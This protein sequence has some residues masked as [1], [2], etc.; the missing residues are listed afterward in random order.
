MTPRMLLA[1]AV[2]Y[3]PAILIGY[4]LYLYGPDNSC[5]LGSLCSFGAFPGI[6]QLF[7]LIVGA[8]LLTAVVFVPLWWLLDEARPARDIVSRTARDMM[9]FVTIRPLL[10]GYGVVLALL[11]L[12]GLLVQR[13]PP[14][15]FLLG[16]SSAAICFWCAGGAEFTPVPPAPPPHSRSASSGAV[17]P[18]Q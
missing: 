12:I 8:G 6:L 17:P 3:N 2:I 13:V 16:L 1:I 7:L 15:I 9:R 11:L 4:L 18:N 10:V 14:S 5:V